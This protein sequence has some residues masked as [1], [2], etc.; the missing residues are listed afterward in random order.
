MRR[1]RDYRWSYIAAA[2]TVVGLFNAE[3]TYV[4][5]AVSGHPSPWLAILGVIA[6]GMILWALLTPAIMRLAERYPVNHRGIGVH[7]VAAL[8]A[9]CADAT[10]YHL[11]DPWVNPFGTRPWLVGFVRYLQINVANYVGVVAIT[12]VVRYSRMLRERQVAEAQ[13]AAQLTTA[14]LRSL[15]AQLRPHFLFNTLNTVAEL[16]HRDP[17]AADRMIARL[18]S[19]LRRSFEAFSEQEVTLETELAFLADYA[20]LVT[21]R[22]A[23]R[24]NIITDIDAEALGASVPSLVLQ[25]LVENAVR[26]GLE[27]SVAGGTVEI[28]ARRR[29]DV[30]ELEV[31]DDGCGLPREHADGTQ[32]WSEGIGIRN[33]RDRLR[34]LH[35]DAHRFSV[36]PRASGGTIVAMQIPFHVMSPAVAAGVPSSANGRGPVAR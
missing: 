10:L 26:H 18:G 28:I 29:L 21:T 8:V 17:E 27:P 9:A 6:P 31:R 20:E 35:G 2:W 1:E 34:H 3:Q 32:G 16:V 12:T 14:H 7:L 15:Q 30:I 36:R 4:T 22:F 24:I 23:G 25:P 33:T 13:M 11:I 19:L 5:L